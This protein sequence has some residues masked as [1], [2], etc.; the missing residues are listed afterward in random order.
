M[1][2]RA[3]RDTPEYTSK[4]EG[5]IKELEK[6]VKEGIADAQKEIEM[7][8]EK[9]SFEELTSEFAV[10]KQGTGVVNSPMVKTISV[11]RAGEHPSYVYLR[12]HR[13]IPLTITSS[14]KSTRSTT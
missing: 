7:E 2:K 4:N 12:P 13:S 5:K 14:F 10:A 9:E 1:K 3:F 8:K 6:F 11:A